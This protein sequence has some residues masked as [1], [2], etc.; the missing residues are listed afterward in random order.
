MHEFLAPLAASSKRISPSFSPRASKAAIGAEGGCS[1]DICQGSFIFLT[2]ADTPDVS[3]F[4][5]LPASKSVPSGQ[6]NQADDFAFAGRHLLAQRLD[7]VDIEQGDRVIEAA[8]SPAGNLP[9]LV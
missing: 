7:D 3:P 9:G 2:A 5:V 1:G 4:C 6:L 8:G